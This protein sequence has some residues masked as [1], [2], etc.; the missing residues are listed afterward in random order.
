MKPYLF[1]GKTIFISAIFFFLSG[2]YTSEQSPSH[3]YQYRG[4]NA[5]AQARSAIKFQEPKTQA[6]APLEPIELRAAEEMLPIDLPT[7]LRLATTENLD[8]A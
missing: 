1:C 5:S 6:S 3:T 4:G 2:C 7:A 8:I